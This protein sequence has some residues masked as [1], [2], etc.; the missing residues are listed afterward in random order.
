MTSMEWIML[1]SAPVGSL[2]F[3]LLFRI[4]PRYLPFGALGGLLSCGVYLLATH[5]GY[6]P[7]PANFA[8][9]L[10]MALYSEIL[11]RLLRAPSSI[12]LVPC[13][14]PLVPGGGLLYTM[15]NLLSRNF[16]AF[17]EYGKNTLLTGLG[18]AGGIVTV[19]ILFA[20]GTGQI[21]KWQQKRGKNDLSGRNASK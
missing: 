5:F 13:S 3:S 15:S 10:C 2:G 16:P 11:A 21:A 19:S 9:S 12:F 18:I 4:R 8:A 17:L 1:L 6:G 20:V 14:I 7:L